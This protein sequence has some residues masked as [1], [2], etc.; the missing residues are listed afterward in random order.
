MADTEKQNFRYPVERWR[1][2]MTK[3][4][5]MRKAGYDID[6]TKVLSAEVDRIIGETADSTAERLGLVA[7]EAPAAVWR[8][9]FA[10]AEADQ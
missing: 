6:M 4:E 5:D 10:R 9:P 8:K 3:L 2:A 1:S 7:G